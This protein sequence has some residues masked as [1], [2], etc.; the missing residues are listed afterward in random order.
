MTNTLC[1][2][3]FPYS[4]LARQFSSNEVIKMMI[5]G[6]EAERPPHKLRIDLPG[7]NQAFNEQAALRRSCQDH[8]EKNHSSTIFKH[9]GIKFLIFIQGAEIIHM[10]QPALKPFVE[11]LRIVELF[12]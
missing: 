2:L 5:L 6:E 3:S 10:L 9:L 8:E 12:E 11:K 7:F 1:P 4:D